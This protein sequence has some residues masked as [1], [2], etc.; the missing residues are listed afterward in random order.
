MPSNGI[1][2][3]RGLV[4]EDK[5]ALPKKAVYE[6]EEDL[7]VFYIDFAGGQK[8]ARKSNHSQGYQKCQCLSHWGPKGDQTGRSQCG[9]G[10]E[11]AAGPDLDWNSLLFGSWGLEQLKLRF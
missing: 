7:V 3:R 9:Q 6:W 8:V 10:H 4:S 5:G 1:H 11:G 2:W